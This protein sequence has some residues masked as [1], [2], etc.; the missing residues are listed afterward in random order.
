MIV[1]DAS[2]ALGALLHDGAARHEV[3]RHPAHVPHLV[4]A[5]VASALRR[6]VAGGGL[7]ATDAW[8]ALEVWRRLGIRR[9][10]MV[11][12]LPRIWELRDN[13]TAYDASYVALAEALGC[14]LLTADA[15]LAAAPGIRCSVQVV[16]G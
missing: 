10:A 16:P 5:E 11:D 7:R 13:V 15:R 6:R 4:D 14:P 1:L 12:H 9:H 2:A 8:R 3:A